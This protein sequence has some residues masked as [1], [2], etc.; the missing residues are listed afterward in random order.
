MISGINTDMEDSKIHEYSDDD[1][2]NVP[3]NGQVAE[4]IKRF[5]HMSTIDTNDDVI[6][7][8]TRFVQGISPVKKSQLK[9]S[10]SMSSTGVDK[11]RPTSGLRKGKYLVNEPKSKAKIKSKEKITNNC[12]KPSRNHT[13]S[14]SK[15][16]QGMR[17]KSRDKQDK[18]NICKTKRVLPKRERSKSI[19]RVAH[20][21]KERKVA[22][23]SYN[24]INTKYVK[25]I[26][27]KNELI[28]A[29]DMDELSDIKSQ[30]I[31][32]ENEIYVER[33]KK[34]EYLGDKKD[35][36]TLKI[37]HMQ[38]IL[39]DMEMEFICEIDR[40]RKDLDNK[41]KIINDITKRKKL[42]IKKQKDT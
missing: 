31:L 5:S 27:L 36:L 8:S 10:R 12:S 18:K 29:S 25:I 1:I 23:V 32:L 34:I 37:Q 9:R 19:S 20:S 2:L 28:K 11:A 3:I 40:F 17:S 14:K 39:N 4:L 41:I 26:S 16:G 38:N 13:R 30:L 7:Q 42:A 35:K 22:P 6:Q 21:E 24:T 33:Q 15:D